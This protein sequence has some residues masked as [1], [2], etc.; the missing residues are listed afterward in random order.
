MIEFEKSV[1]IKRSPQ[2]VFDVIT[3]PPKST[4]WQSGVQ[5]AEW[6]TDGPT[7]VGSTFKSRN[8]LL[9]RDL[10][11]ELMVTEWDPPRLVKIK[12]GSGPIPVEFRNK[13]ESQGDGTLL[14]L[15]AQAEVG[16]FFKLAEGLAGKQIEKQVENDLNNLKLLM[17]SKQL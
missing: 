5:S 7:G 15:K 9:G 4:Q 8:R 1:F 12:T 17:E 13:V 16:G 10:E 11:S 14:T 3:D 2:E 6:T